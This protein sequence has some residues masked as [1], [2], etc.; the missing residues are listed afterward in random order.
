[1]IKLYIRDPTST[2]LYPY[3]PSKIG[4]DEIVKKFLPLT[5][6]KRK[7]IKNKQSGQRNKLLKNNRKKIMLSKQTLIDLSKVDYGNYLKLHTTWQKYAKNLVEK[8]SNRL[9]FLKIDYHGAKIKIIEATNKNLIGIEGIVLQETKYMFV[10]VNEKSEIKKLNKKGILMHFTVDRDV[11]IAV[12]DTNGDLINNVK[13]EPD[14]TSV[15]SKSEKIT[16]ELE[17]NSPT[18]KLESETIKTTDI[19]IFLYNTICNT[20][21]SSLINVKNK[22]DET[23]NPINDEDQKY[24]LARSDEL[25]YS[26]VRQDNKRR[27]RSCIGF[28]DVKSL[29]SN[30]NDG[31]VTVKFKIINKEDIFTECYRI[32]TTIGE[33]KLGISLKVKIPE[34]NLLLFLHDDVESEILA[35]TMT[36]H[37]IG[38]KIN[39]FIDIYLALNNPSMNLNKPKTRFSNLMGD[40]TTISYIDDYGLDRNIV[41]TIDTNN[42]TKP[43]LGGYVDMR[44]NI[45]YYHAVT[46]T[47]PKK[48][49]SKRDTCSTRDTQTAELKTICLQTAIES[50]TQ[51]TGI[52]VYVSTENDQ[53][54]Y[55]TKYITADEVETMRLNSILLIQRYHRRAIAIEKI[56]MLKKMA[57]QRIEWEKKQIRLKKSNKEEIVRNEFKRRMNPKTR[58]DFNLLYNALEKWWNGEYEKINKNFTGAERKAALC[59]LLEQ[60]AILISS[61]GKHRNDIS[62]VNIDKKINNLL[63]RMSRPKQWKSY[64]DGVCS[65]DTQG[66]RQ[67]I[68]TLFLEYIKNPI[69]NPEA[70]RHLKAPKDYTVLNRDIYFCRGCQ[71]YM[72]STNFSHDHI[73]GRCKKCQLI[74]NRAILRND[75]SKYKLILIRLRKSEERHDNPSKI[76]LILKETDMKYIIE[77]IWRGQSILSGWCDIDDLTLCRWNMEESWSPWNMVLVTNEESIAHDSIKDLSKVYDQ[78]IISRVQQKHTLAKSYYHNLPALLM[79]I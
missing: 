20:V 60:E 31:N 50:G 16:Q 47:N 78:A 25:I 26:P 30:E 17:L 5:L 53:I 76:P 75:F 10:L 67:R 72:R 54:G 58:A 14:E 59:E 69:F 64:K 2:N 7:N 49:V 11:K 22:N 40:I 4:F 3:I 34:T 28:I 21:F 1:F 8:F 36:L 41:L 57:N 37:G 48:I 32:F 65:V 33:I 9:E 51:M 61:I 39:G 74:L 55:P 79:N 66:L 18:E 38:A 13:T 77:E 71:N 19:S 35:N 24:N 52:N 70:V 29:K 23:E 56:E 45:E 68:S 62:T 46:Q 44:R 43:F 6:T 15:H 42:Y 63:H 27:V 73:N 12:P